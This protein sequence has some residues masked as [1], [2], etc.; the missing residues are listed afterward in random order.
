MVKSEAFPAFDY[1]TNNFTLFAIRKK[2]IHQTVSTCVLSQRDYSPKTLFNE[3]ANS[4]KNTKSVDR[5]IKKAQ[6]PKHH[7]NHFAFE[8]NCTDSPSPGTKDGKFG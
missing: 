7:Q 8:W 2:T 3:K 6:N 5:A 1:A 4:F